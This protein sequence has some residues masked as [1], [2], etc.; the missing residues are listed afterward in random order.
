MT[1]WMRTGVVVAMCMWPL[2]VA[3]Q[4]R[5]APPTPGASTTPTGTAALGGVVVA[6]ASSKPLRVATVVAIGAFTGVL[7][8]TS[9]DS[10]GRFLFT[11]LPADAYTVAASKAPYLGAVAGAKRAA[12]PGSTV[13]VANGASNTTLTIRLPLAAVI[14]GTI[15][16]DM[17]Q[18]A[19]ALVMAQRRQT[20]NGE[21]ALVTTGGMVPTD[22][23]GR[24]RI[25][26]LPPGDYVVSAVRPG[27]PPFRPRALSE[28]D[29]DAA[30]RAA[31]N[32]AGDLPASTPAGP[33]GRTIAYFY[34]GVARA[35]DASVLT[36]SPGDERSG[37]DIRV[38]RVSG[39][40]VDGTV[41]TAGG[42]PLR[43]A[44]VIMTSGGAF[45]TTYGAQVLADGRFLLS[46]IPPGTYALIATSQRPA[47][48][49]GFASVDVTGDTSVNVVMRA[50]MSIPGVMRFDGAS[51]PS[52]A[53]LTAPFT[54]LST[55]T[56][57][58]GAGPGA[59]P[60]ATPSMSD[61]SFLVTGL[62]PGRYLFG[63]SAYLGPNAATTTWT[64]QS[65][66]ADGR[67]ITDL[68]VDITPETLP[69][70]LVVTLTD[71][72]QGVSGKLQNGEG[73][74]AID[75]TVVIFPADKNY[76]TFGSR[77]IATARPASDG[78]FTLGNSGIASLPPGQ[79]VLAAVTDISKDEQYDP[80][81]LNQLLAAGTPITLVPGERKVQ[82]LVIR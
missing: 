38:D 80:A 29:V 23:L 45:S 26:G 55:Q 41:V 81:L 67:D 33:I 50:L 31:A 10:D 34:P 40:R 7:R 43:Q 76:W 35:S 25:Y 5:D 68:P 19:S 15:T 27:A 39:A 70:A 28:S 53:G 72:W 4:V 46:D 59:R 58:N 52:P 21:T 79:Y 1:R 9:T 22:D 30:L 14:A 18:P 37:I 69:K 32:A 63:G 17:N 61:G 36:M 2:G 77:R 60:I 56:V 12:R 65:I 57:P 62:T 24:Y 11:N 49:F 75:Y 54:S 8:V 64:L 74:P 44:A 3:A 48:L 73:Q 82:N 20:R 13:V 16:D 47:G 71:K 42:Q 66:V 6:D 78:T 51:P